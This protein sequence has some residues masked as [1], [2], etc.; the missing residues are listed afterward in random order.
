MC[1]ILIATLFAVV[2]IHAVSLPTSAIAQVG[3]GAEIKQVFLQTKTARTE[4]DFTQIIDQCLAL[5]ERAAKQD[6]IEYLTKLLSWGLN[7][8]GEF[9][10][11]QAVETTTQSMRWSWTSLR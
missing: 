4:Q 8:R 6:R 10:A 1:R 7:K 2:S 11:A 3:M 9:Y 5:R